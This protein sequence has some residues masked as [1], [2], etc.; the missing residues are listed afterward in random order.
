MAIPTVYAGTSAVVTATFKDTT[1][2]LADPTGVTLTTVS[3]TGAQTAY[4]GG[5]LTHASTG[6][7]TVTVPFATAG[8]W[9]VVAAGSGLVSVVN[10]M[11]VD[12]LSPHA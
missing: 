5:Q 12:V 2:A 1:G 4:S 7:Y 8:S 11:V 10:E 3:P 9:W 6:V